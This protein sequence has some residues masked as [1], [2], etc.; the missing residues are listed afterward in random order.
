MK[1]IYLFA[2][3][4]AIALAACTKT[5]TTSVS[6]GNLIKFDNAFV[7]NPTK[8][9]LDQENQFGTGNLPDKFYVYGSF[10]NSSSLLFENVTVSQSNGSWVYSPVKQWE[11]DHAGNYKFVAYHSAEGNGSPAFDYDSKN[12]TVSGYNSD[13]DHQSDFL[14]AVSDESLR[15]NTPI[16]FS[17][18][19]ALSMIKFTLTSTIGDIKITEFK[20]SVPASAGDVTMND[21]DAITWS[22]QKTGATYTAAEFNATTAGGASDE[23]VIIPQDDAELGITFKATI[24]GIEKN[25]K[26]NITSQSFEPGLRYNYTTTITGADMD[27]IEFTEPTVEPWPDYGDNGNVDLVP[28][29]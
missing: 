8:A 15:N 29:N 6:E 2:A 4:T 11:S 3:V 12:I 21:D 9:G 20:V 14:L 26:A 5:E 18:K 7:G 25:L 16:S 23:F 28:A 17:F 24:D 27:V 13:N 22:G 1:R 10:D 19:H